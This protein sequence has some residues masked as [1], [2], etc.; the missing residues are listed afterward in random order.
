MQKH[1]RRLV[2]L[3]WQLE[4]LEVPKIES[5][6][7]VEL[8]SR[9]LRGYHSSVTRDLACEAPSRVQGE[10]VDP[11]ILNIDS[12]SAIQLY[13]NHVFHDCSK[14]IDTK[15]HSISQCVEEDRVKVEHILTKSLGWHQYAEL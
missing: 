1:H 12:Q 4:H 10:E 3:G 11:F 8:R 9:V 7:L 13:K 14:H 5:G 2:L 15:Y 6:G